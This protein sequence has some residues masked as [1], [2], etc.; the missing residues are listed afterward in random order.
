MRAITDALVSH[1]Q[2]T[3]KFEKV[4]THE[5]TTAPANGMTCAVWPQSLGPLV[6]QS[7]LSATS[8]YLVMQ[9]RVY[10][11]VIRMS[12]DEADQI[13]PGMLTAVDLIMASL[14]GEFTLVDL[15]EAVDLLG[16][17]GETLRAESGYIQIGGPGAGLYRIMTITVPLIVSE[18][19]EQ[20][21]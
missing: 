6:A 13:D 19:W 17:G 14:T 16:I 18:A 20:V 2:L 9:V 15:I 12:P 21:A 5:P 3:G 10:D 11:N 8:A 7:G 4:S 1:V